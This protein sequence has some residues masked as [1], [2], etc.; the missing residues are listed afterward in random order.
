[1]ITATAMFT[2]SIMSDSAGGIGTRITS[3]LVIIPTGKIK[4]CARAQAGRGTADV[5][6][7]QPDYAFHDVTLFEQESSPRAYF[8]E[9]R[10][11]GDPTNW[12]IPNRAAAEAMLRAAGFQI[13][14]HPEPEVFICRRAESPPILRPRPQ[15]VPWLKP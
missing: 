10:Y 5:A 15:E 9:H 8:V 4:S 12:W 2:D 6:A 11:A 1:M 3:T 13:T 7:L 14:D